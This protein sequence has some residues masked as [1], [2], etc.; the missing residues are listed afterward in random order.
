M[1][2]FILQGAYAEVPGYH[3]FAFGMG[4]FWPLR[5][6]WWSARWFA[7]TSLWARFALGSPMFWCSFSLPC[8]SV[9]GYVSVGKD[10]ACLSVV[11]VLVN[12]A[13]RVGS[14]PCA[15]V[16]GYV[17]MGKDCVCLSVFLVLVF[18][19]VCDLISATAARWCAD[20]S[21]WARIA[22]VSPCFWCSCSLP[23]VTSS[24]P[25]RVL[26]YGYGLWARIALVS[27]WFWFSAPLRALVLVRLMGKD[28]LVSLWSWC[29]SPL[30][31]LVCGAFFGQGLRLPLRGPVAQRHCARW[32]ADT[33]YGQG[34]RLSLRGPG[35]HVFSAGHLWLPG[36]LHE[37]WCSVGPC[38]QV[39]GQG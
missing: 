31:A 32:Y 11:L 16:Y 9:C 36:L 1:L 39:H 19:A 18:T 4:I 2:F 17:H 24:A 28:S 10:C 6:L 7:A 3:F 14:L 21:I 15:L 35:T 22:L 30:C 20:T 23:Y 29:S 8:A 25:L 12:T 27:P 34:L 33:A 26:V 5:Q 13:V 37:A 38:T